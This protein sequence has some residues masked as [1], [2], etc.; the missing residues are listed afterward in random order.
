MIQPF[1]AGGGGGG[2]GGRERDMGLGGGG[3]GAVCPIRFGWF[4][5][6]QRWVSVIG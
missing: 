2:G 4:V 5:W 3:G 6:V 1:C